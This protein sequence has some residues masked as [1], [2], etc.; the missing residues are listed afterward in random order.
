[1]I[2]PHHSIS[3]RV[4]LAAKPNIN[5]KHLRFTGQGA[6]T[7]PGVIP[8]GQALII[9]FH[10]YL[11][12]AEA[13]AMVSP[14]AGLFSY[15][16]NQEDR[17]QCYPYINNQIYF[18]Y[19]DYRNDNVVNPNVSAVYTSYLDKWTH[20]AFVADDNYRAV[21]LD[22]VLKGEITSGAPYPLRDVGNVNT[23]QMINSFGTYFPNQPFYRGAID[24]YQV[25][26][27]A[28][29]QA[30]ANAQAHILANIKR[31]ILEPET[32]LYFCS[33]FSTVLEIIDGLYRMPN[34]AVI[35]NEYEK[36]QGGMDFR[37]PQMQLE[38]SSLILNA[39]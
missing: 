2:N 11:T 14:V 15:G 39:N 13:N 8:V 19:G 34:S 21:Y 9:H 18:Q 37:T 4:A 32:G 5:T 35:G 29:G 24:E 25:W 22:G 38:N 33:N 3:N 12:T 20:V 7:M 6:T 16:Q 10:Q 30:R 1:M 23:T 36:A 31:Q 17:C 28:A 27:F 26:F